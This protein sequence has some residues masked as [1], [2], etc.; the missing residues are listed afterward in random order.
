MTSSATVSRKRRR[1]TIKTAEMSRAVSEQYTVRDDVW[2][3]VSQAIDTATM[4]GDGVMSV[5]VDAD[6]ATHG[7]LSTLLHLGYTV[8]VKKPGDCVCSSTPH[9][10][11]CERGGLLISWAKP[12]PAPPP[13]AAARTAQQLSGEETAVAATKPAK[14]VN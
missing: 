3:A 10:V 6:Y 7:M 9:E 13:A 8:V 11:E 5:L 4:R 1:T 12:P 14:E 2:E